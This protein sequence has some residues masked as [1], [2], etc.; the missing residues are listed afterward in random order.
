MFDFDGV[1]I[2]SEPLHFA[3]WQEALRE[4]GVELQRQTYESRLRGYSGGLLLKAITELREPP[5]TIESVAAIYPRKH[6]LFRRRVQEA[7][8][9]SAEMRQLLNDLRGHKLA[10]VSS[11]RH[12]HVD[13]ILER[14]GLR[15]RFQATVCREDVTELK[16]SPEAYL[17]AARLLAVERALVVEDSTAGAESGK[18]GGLRRAAGLRVQ[19]SAP[20]HT[21]AHRPLENN[22]SAPQHLTEPA[23]AVDHSK[24]RAVGHV[25]ARSVKI[26]CI[27][28]CNRIH[29]E[30]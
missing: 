4:L 3:C 6:E 5:L 13:P 1:L 29:A 23:G 26:R 12:D 27:R 17:K 22:S 18:S 10:V 9:M 14:L 7:D 30:L 2:D 16:P 19:R 25:R 11:A 24:S 21:P 8:L 28:R 20:P 15:D